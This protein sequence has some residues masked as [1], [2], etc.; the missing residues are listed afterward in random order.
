[1]YYLPGWNDVPWNNPDSLA[2]HLG[3]YARYTFVV[4]VPENQKLL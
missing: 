4:I 1:M 3:K 2:V